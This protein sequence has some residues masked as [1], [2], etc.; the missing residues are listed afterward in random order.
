MGYML[1]F[2]PKQAVDGIGFLGT[3]DVRV[4]A[5]YIDGCFYKLGG[6]FEGI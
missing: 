5:N 3:L 4:E 2:I 6:P 1:A